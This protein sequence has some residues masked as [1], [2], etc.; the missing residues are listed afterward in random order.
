[1]R[2]AATVALLLVTAA[3]AWAE[4]IDIF[5]RVSPQNDLPSVM[6]MWDSSAN[7]GA[8]MPGDNCSYLDGTGGPKASAPDKEQGTKFGIEKCA[9]YNV[10]YMLPPNQPND[11][12]RFNVGL[13]L[14]NESGAPQGAYPRKALLPLTWDNKVAL[15]TA[16]RSIA[17][18]ADKANNGPYA[19]AMQ[20]LYLMFAKKAYRG[21]P[22]A[23][24]DPGATAAGLYVGP[25]GIGCGRDYIIW[26]SNGSP[27]ENNTDALAV[28]TAD[29]GDTTQ[30]VYPTS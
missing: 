12:A 4:D 25:P 14:F 19:Q 9:I 2:H 29:G 24:W 15:L 3:S 13:A 28:L 17:I 7:W 21:T 6:L 23:K 16:I 18:N 8:N 10:I 5:S 20:E 26:I 1:M 30:L 11:P 22:T 27:N